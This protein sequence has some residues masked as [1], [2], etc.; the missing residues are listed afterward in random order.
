MHDLKIKKHGLL[1]SA[2]WNILALIVAAVVGLILAPI[3]IRG[4]GTEGYGLYSI[5]LMIGGFVAL[6]DMGLGEA[7]LM[8]VSKYY[9]RN[10]LEGIN[11]VLGATLSVYCITGVIGCG[12]IEIFASQIVGI[13][14]IDPGNIPVAIVALRV[15]GISFLLT[16]FCGALQK[17]PEAVQRYDISS[18]LQMCMTVFRY[19]MMI[20][21]V[22]MGVGISGLAA[23]LAGSAM[24]NIIVCFFIAHHLIP[25]VECR[26]HIRKDG[27]REVFSFGI[28]SFINQL[29]S[30]ISLYMDRLILGVFFGTADVGYLAAPKDLLMKVQG[31]SGAAGQALFPRFSAT[32]EGPEMERLY[33]FSLWALTSFSI[34]LFIPA[35]IIMP[36]FLSL[37]VSPEFAE[38]S[39][40]VARL[41][42][43]GLAFNGGTG[44]YVALLKGTGRIQWMTVIFTT[45]AV[46]LTVLT[47]VLV[48]KMGLIG[49]GVRLILASWCGIVIC[50]TVGK[51]V[52]P[53][54]RFTKVLFES[55]VIPVVIGLT[56]FVMGQG[57]MAAWKINSWIGIILLAA[58]AAA[59]LS[60][61]AIGIN[62]IIFRRAGGGA[63]LVQKIISNQK[64]AL[65]MNKLGLG[66]R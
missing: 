45:L 24:I 63:V 44:A 28:F 11:R 31:M 18:K 7:T 55:A 2:F 64:I 33:S 17:I 13:F 30:S 9:A 37:W 16:T 26:P 58:G 15:A 42:A 65:L 57:L 27:L 35:A 60:V 10:D 54:F 3:I 20:V 49:A 41:L 39:A 38:H 14:K 5:I 32:D 46:G 4:I 19:G 36:V 53:G 23:V 52:F 51:K 43:V 61:G 25:G 48:Y 1:T 50:L 22:K 29:I 66:N 8:Y 34:L 47:A 62:W 59:I 40:D 56:V 6:Q 21:V 12:L